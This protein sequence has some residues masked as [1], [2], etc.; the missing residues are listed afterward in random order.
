MPRPKILPEN[1]VRAYRA[2][3]PCKVSKVRCD[4]GLPCANCTKRN[5]MSHCAYYAASKSRQPRRRPSIE[6]RLSPLSQP[7]SPAMTS[8]NVA[9]GTRRSLGEGGVGRARHTAAAQRLAPTSSAGFSPMR[10]EVTSEEAA[11]NTVSEEDEDQDSPQEHFVTGPN[12]ETRK[13]QSSI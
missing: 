8:T 9:Y 2:C 10:V 6:P 7:L 4:S 3:D 5:R 12:G 11:T 13:L 1:R